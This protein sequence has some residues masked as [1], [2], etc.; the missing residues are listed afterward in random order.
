MV[1]C[2]IDVDN[3]CSF[4]PQDKV[5][6]FSRYTPQQILQNTLKSVTNRTAEG[7]SLFTEQS[8]LSSMESSKEEYRRSKN[9]KEDRVKQLTQELNVMN[10]EIEKLKKRDQFKE[11]LKLCEIKHAKLELDDADRVLKEAQAAMQ[12]AEDRKSTESRKL[13][14]L[15]ARER[16]LKRQQGMTAQFK[17]L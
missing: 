6:A 17:H 8:E 7:K 14:P 1:K 16:E 3:L 11:T 12:A 5:G 4:M 10:A 13:G 2:S 9:A 15:E